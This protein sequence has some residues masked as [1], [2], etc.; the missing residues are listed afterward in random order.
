MDPLLQMQ[1]PSRDNLPCQ[2]GDVDMER[3]FEGMQVLISEAAVDGLLE[4]QRSK[5]V[6][7]E[8]SPCTIEAT[9]VEDLPETFPDLQQDIQR[10]K[11]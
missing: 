11:V 1:Q 7:Q 8:P 3:L 5:Q 4:K 10:S 6:V 9:T 2:V